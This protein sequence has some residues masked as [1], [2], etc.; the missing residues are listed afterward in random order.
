M[1]FGQLLVFALLIAVEL[2]VFFVK[3]ARKDSMV[4]ISP[5][6][7]VLSVLLFFSWGVTFVNITVLVLSLVVFILNIPALIK[8]SAKLLTDS[9]SSFSKS[10][11]V[12]VTVLCLAGMIFTLIFAPVQTKSKKIGVHEFKSYYEGN[13][14][15]G[16]SPLKAGSQTSGILYQYSLS[17]ELSAR[18]NAVILLTD[19]RGD[20]PAYIPFMQYLAKEGYTVCA[21]DFYTDDLTWLNSTADRRIFRH[22]EM[23][24]KS[25]KKDSVFEDSKNTFKYNYI[26][27]CN[28]LINLLD[29]Q[30]GENCR[31]FLIGDKMSD[32]AIADYA[33]AYPDKISGTF[34]LDSIP[35]YKTAGYG[36]IEYTD[37]L[38]A[39]R[40]GQKKDRQGFIT[41]Y[42][43]LKANEE[44]R[45][46][47]GMKPKTKK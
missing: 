6:G 35:E 33:K 19:K 23:V 40:L 13:F 18:K 41:K 30:F 39:K 1:I 43:V 34:L 21:M 31:Y 2:R 47:L 27:E 8:F 24:E 17:P 32:E 11:A 42:L 15:S 9:Y 5:L 26:K 36:C 29:L 37:P 28:A 44:I 22:F 20:G 46:A 7:L 38:L 25:L 4:F 10:C 45:K 12:I 3:Q 16:L 14:R